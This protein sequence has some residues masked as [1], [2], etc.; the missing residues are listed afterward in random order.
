MARKPHEVSHEGRGG[1]HGGRQRHAGQGKLPAR[2]I[3]G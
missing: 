3:D 1:G 2:Q